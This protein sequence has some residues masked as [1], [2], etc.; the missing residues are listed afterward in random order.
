MSIAPRELPAAEHFGTLEER[1]AAWVLKRSSGDIELPKGPNPAAASILLNL[2]QGLSPSA[3]EAFF[4]SY[5]QM[6][7]NYEF[8]GAVPMPDEPVG[9]R[10]VAVGGVIAAGKSTT[11]AKVKALLGAPVVDSDRTRKFM[12]GVR[13]TERIGDGSWSGHYDPKFTDEVYD[14]VYRRAGIVLQSGRPVILD[15]SFR[16]VS[17]RDRARRLAEVHGV[18]FH[19]VECCTPFEVCRERLK[20]RDLEVTVSDGRLEVFDAFVSKW[21]APTELSDAEHIPLDTQL[22]APAQEAFLR[23][24]LWEGASS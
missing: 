13:S 7:Q 6:A 10:V 9:P 12:V 15:A 17:M 2:A 11:C 22:L 19:F 23:E 16:S 21:E 3:R 18:P 24:R 5:A 8:F 14:E 4:A 1:E 20:K